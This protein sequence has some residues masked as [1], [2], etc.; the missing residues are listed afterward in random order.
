MQEDALGM[1]LQEELVVP[2]PRLLVIVYL[3]VVTRFGLTLGGMVGSGG[4]KGG[5]GP[6]ASLEP[7]DFSI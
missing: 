4:G 5:G 2:T 7:L 1:I 3:V 6:P